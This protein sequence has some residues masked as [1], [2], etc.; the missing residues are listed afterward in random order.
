MALIK[1][2]VSPALRS[3]L[4]NRFLLLAITGSLVWLVGDLVY[5]Y[6]RMELVSTANEAIM[7]RPHE[8]AEA[9]AYAVAH[10]PFAVT[11]SQAGLVVMVVGLAEVAFGIAG[12]FLT[13]AKR[14]GLHKVS[15]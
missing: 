7:L 14:Q 3:I 15:A 2:H 1:Q 8:H 13:K 6:A 12:Y 10:N 11:L 9:W 4:H 5:Y